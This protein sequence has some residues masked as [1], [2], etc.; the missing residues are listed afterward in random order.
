[1]DDRCSGNPIINLFGK[2]PKV[3]HT[4]IKK[5][6]VTH[7]SATPT[8]YRLMLDNETI[9]PDV[10]QISSGGEKLTGTIKKRL[11]KTFPNAKIKNIYASTE[12]GSLFSSEGEFFKIPDRYHDKINIINNE[13]IIHKSLLGNSESLSL[14]NDWYYSGDIVEMVDNKLFRFITRKNKTINVGGYKVNPEE[15]EEALLENPNISQARVYGKPNPVLGNILCADVVST[16]TD[17][18]GIR[19][20]LDLQNFKIP[21]IINFKDKVDMTRTGKI[22][23]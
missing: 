20:K 2:E 8:F 12:A 14:E 22:K 21:R 7:L 6:N 16:E 11:L 10:V 19:K 17:E 9:L 13:I 4:L 1:M 23:R 5:Y 15:V 3:I 18:N